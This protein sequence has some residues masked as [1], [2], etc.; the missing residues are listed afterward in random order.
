MLKLIVAILLL[1]SSFTLFAQ[2]DHRGGEL[3]VQLTDNRQV[4]SQHSATLISPKRNIWL[5]SFDTAQQSEADVLA[6]YRAM[7]NVRWAQFNHLVQYRTDGVPN[8]PFF[9]KQWNMERIGM[10]QIWEHFEGKGV[11][12]QNDTIVIAVIDA[13]CDLDHEDLLPRIWR[14]N[15][16]I[17]D[18]DVDND[19]NGYID[20]YFGWRVKTHDDNHTVSGHGTMVAGIIGATGNNEVGVSGV[21]QHIKLMIVSGAGLES[22]VVEAFDYIIAAREKYNQTNGAAGAFVVAVNLSFGWNNAQ[23]SE[24]PLICEGLDDLGAAGIISAVATANNA[25]DVDV[26]G[27]VP[28]GCTSPYMIA[29][30]ATTTAD[31]RRSA[32]AYG[33]TS[34]DIGA[35]GEFITSTYTNNTYDE[36]NGTSFASPHVA[37]AVGLLYALPSDELITEAKTTP[38]EATQKVR[39]AILTGA[40]R[41]F[42]LKDITTTGGRLNVWR[43]AGALRNTYGMPW[44]E[45]SNA[46]SSATASFFEEANLSA[47]GNSLSIQLSSNGYQPLSLQLCDMTG[48]TVLSYTSTAA[49]YF[50]PYIVVPTPNLPTGLY[51]AYLQNGKKIASKKIVVFR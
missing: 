10:P 41:I 8:D 25:V 45:L 48:R 14:N 2:P 27:D 20:D 16:E 11:T 40:D 15:A 46:D 51:I 24:Y 34:I 3:L 36:G 9:E 39:Q 18:D 35:P 44:A 50:A 22:E 21:N 26:V 33:A 30:T 47:N 42:A 43:A 5:V 4:R 49:D 13:G 1:I 32:S 37:G 31:K 23:P 19:Q 17:Q 7:P 12:T 29:V 6:M 28:T 38:T